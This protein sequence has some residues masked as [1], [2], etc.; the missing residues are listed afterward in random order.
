MTVTDQ[1]EPTLVA[2]AAPTRPSWA[3][4]PKVNLLPPEIMDGRRFAGLK[5]RLVLLVLLVVLGGAAATWWA[6]TT[7]GAAQGEVDQAQARTAA[8]ATEQAKYAEV[9]RVTAAVDAA[10]AV[11]QQAMAADV[12]WYR[13]LNDVA[14]ATTSD[15]YLSSMTATVKGATPSAGTDP[16]APAGIGAVQISGTA[17]SLP[18]VAAWMEALDQ[19]TGI[20]GSVLVSAARGG[21]GADIAFSTTS[22]L[23]TDS[24]S[25][26]YDRRAG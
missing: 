3:V 5:R 20:K 14:L 17:G 1:L 25:H 18:S 8:L 15:V 2:Q 16:L 10:L 7:V 24:L 26:R 9:P 11:R 21:S 6:Q 19:I 12:L 4:V 23:T 13:Y 22:V